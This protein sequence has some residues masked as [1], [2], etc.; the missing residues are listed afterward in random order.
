MTPG[1]ADLDWR[2][3]SAAAADVTDGNGEEVAHGGSEDEAAWLDLIG[4]F[5]APAYSGDEPVPWP[6]SEA[7]PPAAARAGVSDAS[8]GPAG[9]RGVTS[10]AAAP[11][12]ERDSTVPPALAAG[13][14]FTPP[15]PPTGGI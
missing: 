8:A 13:L 1:A 5:D 11:G 15:S 2:G 14:G 12:P 6:A 3:V 9:P 4:R 10:G 7:V